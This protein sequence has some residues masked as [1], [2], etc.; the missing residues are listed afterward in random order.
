MPILLITHK[1]TNKKKRGLSSPLFV[2]F[3]FDQGE[4]NWAALVGLNASLVT[5]H[6][7][8][9]FREFIQARHVPA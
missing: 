7:T 1:Q 5:K 2:V 8:L 6:H 9:H 4:L 3:N